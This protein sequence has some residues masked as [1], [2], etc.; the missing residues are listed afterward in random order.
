MLTAKNIHK[1]TLWRGILVVAFLIIFALGYPTRMPVFSAVSLPYEDSFVNSDND[2]DTVD[3]WVESEIAPDDATTSNNTPRPTSPTIVNASLRKGASI[4]QTV[5]T[6]GFENITFSFY[7]HGDAQAELD[8]S[9]RLSALWRV[10]DPENPSFNP[11]FTELASYDL[12]QN[13][14]TWSVLESYSL[15]I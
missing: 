15:G 8:G 3:G 10:V 6:A 5:N 13:T 1:I 11:L 4:I 12:S 7:W 9:D 2:P 14:T